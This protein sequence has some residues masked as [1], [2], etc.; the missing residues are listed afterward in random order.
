MLGTERTAVA[1]SERRTFRC[2]IYTRKSSEHGLEQD[3]N[4]LDAQREAAEAYIKS[5]AHEG[6]KL[7]KTHYDD[8]GLSGGT[9]ERPA[10]QSLLVDI[11]ARKIDIVV[12]YKVDRLTRSLADFAKLVELFEGHGVSFVSVT[13]QFNTTTSMGRLTLNI[14]L[15]FAQFERE[16]AGERIRD[17]FAASRRKGM[18]MGGTIPL[19]YNVHDRKLIVNEAEAETVRLIFARH[20]LLGCVSKLRADLDRKGVWSKQ[21]ILTSGRV[22]GGC[23]FDRGALYHL[24]RNRIYRGKVIHKGIAYPGEQS[25]I[26]DEELWNAVQAKLSGNLARRRTARIESG[27]V[28]GGLIF[29]DRGNCMSPTYTTHLGSR[30]RYYVSQARLRG[31]RE[32]SRPRIGA[33]DVERLIVEQLFRRQRRD[34]LAA[35]ITNGVWSAETRE[36]ILTMVDRV[37]VHHDEIEVAH[38]IKGECGTAASIDG[39]DKN[40]GQN[41]LRLPLPPHRPRERREILIPG[42]SGTQPRRIDQALILA[43]ARARIWMCALQQSEFV[44]SAEIAKRFGLSDAHVRRLLRLAYLAPDIVEAIVEGRQPRILTVKLLLKGISLDWADQRAAFG[45]H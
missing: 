3:F 13:Q 27:A 17:K 43:L 16:I 18:W 15:S 42:N 44:K 39:E 30:Y 41:A 10:L 45:F 8:G 12:V 28:L 37:I 5:Q 19:G 33:D 34:D 36:L 24:L 22:L 31:N 6:W 21:R 35:D 4:S 23:S 9:L 2:A 14:L 29:D 25:A 1:A 11:Q 20:L 7:I 26:V 32:G 40:E 38:K